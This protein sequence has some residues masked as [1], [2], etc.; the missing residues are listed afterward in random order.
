MTLMQVL[1]LA[2]REV[3]INTLVDATQGLTELPT[4]LVD[5]LGKLTKAVREEKTRVNSRQ[6]RTVLTS[7]LPAMSELA[8]LRLQY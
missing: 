1:S 8:H 7:K 3:E 2:H 6:R 4:E 5:P